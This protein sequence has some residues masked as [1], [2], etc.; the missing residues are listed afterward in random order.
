ML[1][2]PP[3]PHDG[4]EF[5]GRAGVVLAGLLAT[6][7]LSIAF[8]QAS[9][10]RPLSNAHAYAAPAADGLITSEFAHWHG[11]RPGARRSPDWEMTSGSLFSRNGLFWTGIP[12]SCGGDA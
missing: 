10:R 3:T 8:Y 2:R 5:A 9:A 4:R 11:A 12:D 6:A 1:E 7:A